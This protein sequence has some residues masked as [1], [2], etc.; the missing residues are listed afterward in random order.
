MAGAKRCALCARPAPT[1]G[2]TG[3]QNGSLHVDLHAHPGM[4]AALEQML[5]LGQ[6]GDIEWLP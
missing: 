2:E 6:T 3:V 1:M 4:D 5:P